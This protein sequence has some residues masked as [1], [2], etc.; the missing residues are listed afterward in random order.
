MDLFIR[1]IL[2]SSF[3]VVFIIVSAVLLF[4]LQGFRYNAQKGIVERTG[5]IVAESIPEQATVV[6]NGEIKKNTT[7]S[8]FQSL[9]P[10]DY[11]VVINMSGWQT[12]HKIITV[13]P[14]RATFTGVVHLWPTPQVGERITTNPA[15]NVTSSPDR[16]KILY[17]SKS[18]LSSGIWLLNLAN[19]ETNIIARPSLTDILSLEWTNSGKEFL[20]TQKSL[21]GNNFQI[22]NLSERQWGNLNFPTNFS[23]SIIHFNED[24]NIIY[25]YS[26]NELYQFN[27]RTHSL[28]LVWREKLNDFR[29][30]DGLIFG[31]VP[32]ESGG[33]N[34]KILNLSN[35]QLVPMED[36]LVLS[37]SLAFLESKGDWLPLFDQDRHTLYLLHSPLTELEPIRRLPEITK[38]DWAS[39]GK[40]I[41]LTNNFEMWQYNI[42]DNKLNLLLRVSTPLTQARFLNNEP[43]LIYTSGTKV[44]GLELDTRGEQQNWLLADYPSAVE[45]IFIDPLSKSVNVKLPDGFWRINLKPNLSQSDEPLINWP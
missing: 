11:E 38:I 42:P 18:G 26:Q 20:I 10:G 5:A 17:Y 31:L 37:T 22:F 35:L 27:R 28:K 13:K 34:L 19:G 12:W 6:I 2:Y 44:W 33:I 8:S 14:S 41:L 9:N 1:R 43:Y 29:Y 30:H 21:G 23:P 32:N 36:S 7:P 4:Y 25:A 40:S 45:D 15:V 16:S 39:D 3:F 24:E